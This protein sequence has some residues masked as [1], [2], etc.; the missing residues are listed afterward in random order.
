MG[1]Q[2]AKLVDENGHA[3]VAQPPAL[4]ME[5]E[6][7]AVLAII[8]RAASDPT[9]DIEKM[10]VLMAM[11]ADMRSEDA[12]RAFNIAMSAA[13]AEMRPIAADATNPQTKSKYAS[14]AALDRALRPIYTGQGFG[15]SFGTAEGGP[16]EHVRVTCLVTH[17]NG[18]E[19]TY[20]ADMPADG[21]GAKGGDV[22]TKTHA[23]GAALTYGQRYL[24]KMIFNI[25]V[26]PDDDGNAA[27]GRGR[28]PPKEGKISADQLKE[29][30]TLMTNRGVPEQ[31][32]L[33]WAK[34]ETVE[35]IAADLFASCV[36]AI[37]AYKGRRA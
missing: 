18:H 37:Y 24:L 2:V 4:P 10:K 3:L 13:Q 15:L 16:A 22:M 8:S 31:Q 33:A 21:K 14:Y 7:A 5:S 25:A 34:V 6:T 17:A 9:V 29:L 30:R 19:R 1:S 32:F 12:R 35:D 26:G 27:S 28:L 23:T 11:R 20:Q 36:N